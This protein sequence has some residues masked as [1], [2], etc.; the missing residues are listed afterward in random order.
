MTGTNTF[1][2]GRTLLSLSGATIALTGTVIMSGSNTHALQIYGGGSGDGLR[3]TGGPTN[4][5]GV[6]G[7]GVANGWGVRRNR[8]FN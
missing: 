8:W 7:F 6:Q 4:G 3:A 2:H 5:D 1:L